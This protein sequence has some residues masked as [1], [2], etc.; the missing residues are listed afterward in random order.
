MKISQEFWNNLEPFDLFSSHPQQTPTQTS[1]PFSVFYT[2]S[3]PLAVSMCWECQTVE[4][5]QF[6]QCS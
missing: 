2:G 4:N 6:P 1:F 3:L 5:P